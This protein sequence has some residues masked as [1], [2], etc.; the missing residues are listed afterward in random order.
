M[1]RRNEGEVPAQAPAMASV[2]N[3][4]LGQDNHMRRTAL[5]S[6]YNTSRTSRFRYHRIVNTKFLIITPE[7]RN[8]VTKIRLVRQR[9]WTDGMNTKNNHDK[10]SSQ[11]DGSREA[12]GWHRA[13]TSTLLLCPIRDLLTSAQM[14]AAKDLPLYEYI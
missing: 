8:R 9:K 13:S 6:E 5:S 7:V 3:A 10:R 12:V 11:G 2:A 1:R 14:S 4:E